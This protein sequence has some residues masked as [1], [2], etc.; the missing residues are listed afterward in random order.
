MLVTTGL[1]R[2]LESE[3][4][5]AAVLAHEIAHVNLNHG[6]G[7]IQQAN[8]TQAFLLIGK[9]VVSESA[10]SDLGALTGVFEASVED[11]LGRMVVSG[12]SREQEY[13]ADRLAAEILY[14]SG[15]D[16]QGLAEFFRILAQVKGEGGFLDTH[17]PAPERSRDFERLLEDRGW[18]GGSGGVRQTRFA[19]H[20][21]Q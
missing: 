21:L 2:L 17:P 11:I 4:Q 14:R 8:L 10:G 3:D 16:P 5:L 19:A 20:R 12:Y 13:A 6:L 1:Y 9:A 15:Y 7:A 18:T